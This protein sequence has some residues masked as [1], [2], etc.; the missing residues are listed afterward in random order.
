[1]DCVRLRG[2]DPVDEIPDGNDAHHFFVFYHRQVAHYDH[3]GRAWMKLPP[4]Q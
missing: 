1:M 4:R 2:D 3:M